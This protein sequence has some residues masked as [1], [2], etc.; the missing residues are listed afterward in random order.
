MPDDAFSPRRETF[1]RF[2]SMNSN[3]GTLSRFD[4]INSNVGYDRS[5]FSSFD[6]NDPFGSSGPFKVSSESQNPRKG[7]DNWNSF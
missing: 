6:D 2:D 5:R 7:S 3:Q 4:S 1:S